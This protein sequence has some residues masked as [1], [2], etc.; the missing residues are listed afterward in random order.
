MRIGDRGNERGCNQRTDA[1]NIIKAPADFA[2][3]VPSKDAPVRIEDL[4]LYHLKPSAQRQETITRGGRYAGIVAIL[5]DRQQLLQ[6]VATNPGDNTELGQMGT[7]GIDQ[8]GALADEQRNDFSLSTPPSTITSTP[9]VTRSREG[10]TGI[11]AW[12]R[13]CH[14][15][16]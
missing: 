2:R 1:R 7:Q 8:R 4:M 5:D 16:M 11:S 6:P 3:S 9:S 13:W 10:I 12:R 14:G 15:D